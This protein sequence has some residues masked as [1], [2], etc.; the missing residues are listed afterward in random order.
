MNR[1]STCLR[2][3]PVKVNLLVVNVGSVDIRDRLRVESILLDQRAR[4]DPA[5]DGPKSDVVQSAGCQL[6]ECHS[7]VRVLGCLLDQLHLRVAQTEPEKF[8]L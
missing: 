7:P 3:G 5:G 2:R 4:R 6:C 8:T 1:I